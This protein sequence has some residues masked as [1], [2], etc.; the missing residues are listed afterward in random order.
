MVVDLEG[1]VEDW[2]MEVWDMVD[3]RVLAMVDMQRPMLQHQS[4]QDMEDWAMEVLAMEV[5][6]EDMAMEVL[7]DWG[8]EVDWD[9]EE[10]IKNNYSC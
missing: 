8:T 5:L 4:M 2:A 3:T 10:S 9:M 6:V 1:M 7:E